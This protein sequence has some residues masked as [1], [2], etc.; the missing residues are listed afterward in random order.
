MLD[1]NIHYSIIVEAATIVSNTIHLMI[2][3]TPYV[4][5]IIPGYDWKDKLI[6]T[7]NQENI[8]HLIN[9]GK[10]VHYIT[11]ALGRNIG[12][13]WKILLLTWLDDV[14]TWAKHFYQNGKEHILETAQIEFESLNGP[15]LLE[16][17]QK[18][19]NSEIY[20]IASRIVIEHFT[21]KND[22]E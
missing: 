2:I 21:D 6:S 10:L 7:S 15:D 3:D 13:D 17:L 16:T 14:F 4:E 8:Y 18:T 20:E 5:N 12:N 11:Y 22:L 1:S 19:G 9:T